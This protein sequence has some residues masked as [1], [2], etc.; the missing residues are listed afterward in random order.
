MTAEW[1]ILVYCV[2]N[3]PCDVQHAQ[4]AITQMRDALDT[5]KINIVFQLNTKEPMT[6]AWITLADK[7]KVTTANGPVDT[8]SPDSISGFIDDVAKDLEAARTALVLFGHGLGLDHIHP[9]QGIEVIS[10][11]PVSNTDFFVALTSRRRSV[12]SPADLIASA[13]AEKQPRQR[14][15]AP[16]YRGAMDL[17]IDEIAPRRGRNAWPAFMHFDSRLFLNPPP[18]F[19]PDPN[20]PE[21]F[22]SNPSIRIGIQNCG[23]HKVD[24]LALN[25][26]LMGMPE[27]AYEVADVADVLVSCEVIAQ[28]WP[29]DA[30]VS[31]LSSSVEANDLPA[32]AF[33]RAIVTACGPGID[34]RGDSISAFSL[35]QPMTYLIQSLDK[36]A[37]R[38]LVLLAAP[39]NVSVIHAIE[40]ATFEVDG[41]RANLSKLL[42]QLA[43]VDDAQAQALAATV[44]DKLETALI[45]NI[46]ST[47]YP[48][49]KGLAIF[50]PV[51][52]DTDVAAAYEGMRFQ[53]NN[54]GKFLIA[55]QKL[56]P[57]E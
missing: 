29:Y 22:L 53:T 49:A 42:Q 4:A 1:N 24:V 57:S 37:A 45:D 9:L 43:T 14:S 5:D 41:S 28:P 17:Q 21:C 46:T 26:C 30:I 2:A 38:M 54:W 47:T 25:A 33:G 52:G 11:G 19:G 56:V 13:S 39:D 51:P 12:F 36:F 23:R 55:A 3:D 50:F 44:E 31:A 27:I 10:P 8:S 32:S 20:H 40:S 18:Y 6:R 34:Q 15:R 16:A 48:Q 7:T 35:G